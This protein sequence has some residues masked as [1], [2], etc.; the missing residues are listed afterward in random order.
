MVTRWTSST[1]FRS[2]SE[3]LQLGARWSICPA[4]C[5]TFWESSKAELY[6]INRWNDLVFAVLFIA[7]FL[8]FVAVSVI[9]LRA[10][11]ASNDTG[12]LGDVGNSITLNSGTAYLLAIIAGAALVFSVILLLIV[13]AFTKIILEI[14]LLLSVLLNIAYAVYLWIVKY[15]SGA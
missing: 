14:T 1:R 13:R 3:F 2:P 7:Q 9:A 12:G 4:L 6:L 15:Y 10:L 11:G 8:G 5:D